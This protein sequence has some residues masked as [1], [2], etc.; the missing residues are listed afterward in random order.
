MSYNVN[1]KKIDVVDLRKKRKKAAQQLK[2]DETFGYVIGVSD[3]TPKNIILFTNAAGK[4][5]GKII[6]KEEKNWF[7][8]LFNKIF[9]RNE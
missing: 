4:V 2:E 1:V 7:A 8:K 5:V 3:H 6:L 9:R